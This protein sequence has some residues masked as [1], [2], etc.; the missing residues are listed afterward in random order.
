MPLEYLDQPAY[1]PPE[2]PPFGYDQDGNPLY[3]DPNPPSATPQAAAPAPAPPIDS[4]PGVMDTDDEPDPAQVALDNSA[5]TSQHDQGYQPPPPPPPHLNWLQRIIHAGR[6][7][8]QVAGVPIATDP[9]ANLNKIYSEYPVKQAP[10][11]LQRIAAGTLGGAAGWSNAA[12]RAAPINIPAVT[13]N[14]LYPGYESKL[15]AWQSR[16]VPA[17]QAVT[18]A[19]QRAAADYARQNAENKLELA[20]AKAQLDLARGT[21]YASMADAREVDVTPEIAALS[22]GAYQVGQKITAGALREITKAAVAAPPPEREIPAYGEVAKRMGVPEGKPVPISSYNAVTAAI[23]SGQR[24][25]WASYMDQAGGDDAKAHALWLNDEIKKAQASRDPFSDVARQALMDRQ[26]QEDLDRVTKNQIDEE[27]KIINQRAIGVRAIQNNPNL[28]GNK[29][30]QDAIA[31]L[32]AQAKVQLQKIKDAARLSRL[33]RKMTGDA[34]TDYEVTGFNPDGT[35]AYRVR[36][37]PTVTSGATGATG[38]SGRVITAPGGSGR[39]GAAGAS[40]GRGAAPARRPPIGHPA[41]VDG[42]PGII[43]GFNAQGKPIITLNQ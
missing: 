26:Q 40:G 6:G 25:Q 15:A 23:A 29:A 37:A 33:N 12:R 31:N 34:V 19:G 18:I 5:A 8:T 42:K 4:A 1:T 20:S 9:Y 7:D 3:E 38:G 39:G 27:N 43:T 22:K 10:N 28:I 17:E 16:V 14:V 2:D 35:A 13:N 32:D 21:N 36:G 41:T 24:S 30:K 11:L